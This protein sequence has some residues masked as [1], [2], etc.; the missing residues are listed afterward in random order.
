LNCVY[1]IDYSH[2]TIGE[3]KMKDTI[4]YKMGYDSVINKPNTKNC[5]FSL[6]STHEKMKRWEKGVQDAK[7]TKVKTNP[8]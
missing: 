5:H 1:K 8:K 4:E 2:L 3:Y 6:F 7:K